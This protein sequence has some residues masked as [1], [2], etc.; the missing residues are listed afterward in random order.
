MKKKAQQTILI[1]KKRLVVEV[2]QLNKLIVNEEVIKHIKNTDLI[3]VLL[4][5]KFLNYEKFQDYLEN[6]V[7]AKIEDKNFYNNR[8]SVL[9]TLLSNN[10][11]RDDKDLS[12]SLVSKLINVLNALTLDQACFILRLYFKNKKSIDLTGRAELLKKFKQLPKSLQLQIERRRWLVKYIKNRRVLGC[13]NILCSTT[14]FLI[15]A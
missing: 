2:N 7:V 15:M 12:K 9:S 11:I 3:S 10:S 4:V 6:L 1:N 5:V 13:Y 14:R 8:T